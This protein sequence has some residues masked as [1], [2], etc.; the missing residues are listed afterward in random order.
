MPVQLATFVQNMLLWPRVVIKRIFI[1][2]Q[3]GKEKRKKRENPFIQNTGHRYIF[4]S[5]TGAAVHCCEIPRNLYNAMQM[6]NNSNNKRTRHSTPNGVLNCTN[7][8]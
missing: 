2:S 6:E 3:T 5:F 1:P 7:T 8:I 4:N